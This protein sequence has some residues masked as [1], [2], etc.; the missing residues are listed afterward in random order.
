MSSLDRYILRQ[1]L[2][3]FAVAISVVTMIVWMT[4]SLQRADV[5]V[6]YSQGLQVFARLSLLIIPSL[7]TVII[8]FSLFAAAL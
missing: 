8:P 4:Q 6:E 3:P 7:L 5:I 2:V 1:C